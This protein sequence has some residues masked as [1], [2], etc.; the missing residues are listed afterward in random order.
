VDVDEESYHLQMC[1][2]GIR[3]VVAIVAVVG[4]GQLAEEVMSVVGQ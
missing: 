1:W 3:V 2:V 4:L